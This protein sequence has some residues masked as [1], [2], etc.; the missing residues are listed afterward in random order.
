[1]IRGKVT[2]Q[3]EPVVRARVLGRN[4]AAAEVELVIDTGF[5]GFLS[6]APALIRALELRQVGFRDGVLADGSI[7]LF[8]SHLATIDWH[9]AVRTGAVIKSTG[10]NL[11]GMSLLEGSIL[12]MDTIR[13]RNRSALVLQVQ[14]QRRFSRTLR[15][16]DHQRRT[17]LASRRAELP[18][19]RRQRRSRR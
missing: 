7:V 9:G 8:P 12:H 15:H 11:L 14:V 19:H 18:G 16:A 3:V 17:D 13:G 5:N 4:G 10:G 1:M 2:M 6:L